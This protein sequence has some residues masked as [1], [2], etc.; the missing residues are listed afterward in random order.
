MIHF[1]SPTAALVA[2]AGL[3]PLA[4][5]LVVERRNERARALLGLSAPPPRSPD[6]AS[7]AS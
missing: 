2:L 6:R 1:D 4:L 3:V 7:P 5:V